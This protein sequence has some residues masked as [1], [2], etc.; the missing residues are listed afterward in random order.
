MIK[1]VFKKPYLYYFILIFLIY[2]ILN[3]IFSQF[4]ITIQY[5]PKY[6]ETIKWQELITSALLSL[7]IGFL[8]SLNSLL[9]YI[10]YKERK[11]VKKQG[12]LATLGI[13][14][15]FATGVC[16]ACVAGLFPLIF[17]LFGISFSFLSLPLKGIEIQILVILI[18]LINLY[19]LKKH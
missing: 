18:L 10:K 1:Q 14:G 3:V 5:I 7:A 15:G 4:Y 11:N 17:G 19:F 8:V 6:L 16:S 9:V 12:I 13:M 2:L